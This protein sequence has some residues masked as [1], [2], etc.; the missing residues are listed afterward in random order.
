MWAR[1]VRTERVPARRLRPTAPPPAER[2]AAAA[3]AL[4]GH[5]VTATAGD[6]YDQARR[7]ANARLDFRPAEIVYCYGESDVAAAIQYGIANGMQL[8]VRSGGHDYEGFSL[9]NGGLVI[10]VS[11]CDRYEVSADRRTAIVGPGT[12]LRTL[13]HRL[14]NTRLDPNDPNDPGY[15]LPGGSCGGVGVGGLV[16][17]GGFGLI[18]RKYGLF[19]DRLVRVRLVDGTG[20]LREA[21]RVNDPDGVLWATCGGGGGNF[22]VVTELEFELVR[23]PRSV[24]T[25]AYVWPAH[26]DLITRLTHSFTAWNP[27]ED[28]FATLLLKAGGDVG[29][30]VVFAGQSFG[31]EEATRAEIA[32]IAGKLPA[33]LTAS[34]SPLQS[35]SPLD[36]IEANAG[37]DTEHHAWKMASSLGRGALN[38]AGIGALL[39]A[40]RKGP[41]S[42]CYVQF[43]TFGGKINDVAADATAFP[44]RDMTYTVQYQSYWTNP[45]DADPA[46]RWLRETFE[47]VD[48]HIGA[49]ASYR[50]YCDLNLSDWE[51]RYYKANYARLQRIK[52][53]LDPNNTFYYPQSIVPA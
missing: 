42:S 23:A 14:G 38:T 52:A 40:L 20:A 16:T 37:D 6:E 49:N 22:G 7:I 45:S 50:N 17:G 13:Y 31:D 34:V 43:D 11:R 15:T 30:Q 4:S 39:E 28:V 2:A 36:A 12:P 1:H 32:P 51:D 33:P 5:V 24:T 18:S 35:M 10:D 21:T 8:C 46:E 26:D 53:Q 48:A 47:A 41:S 9:N 19:C 27:S 44:H 3:P 25:F 29:S